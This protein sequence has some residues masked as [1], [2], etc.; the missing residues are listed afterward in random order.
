[1]EIPFLLIYLGVAIIRW[2]DPTR[3]LP[4]VELPEIKVG[5]SGPRLG[6]LATTSTRDQPRVYP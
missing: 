1:M 2:L 5:L 3:L 6:L 4:R